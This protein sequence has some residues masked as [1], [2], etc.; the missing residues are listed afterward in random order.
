MDESANPSLRRMAARTKAGD[1]SRNT[2]YRRS[3]GRDCRD[4]RVERTVTC[5]H[6]CVRA[7][8]RVC[9]ISSGELIARAFIYL[10]PAN[11]RVLF[12][13]SVFLSVCEI[14]SIASTSVNNAGSRSD[15]YHL[16][17][18][19]SP[20]CISDECLCRTRMCV[21]ACMRVCACACACM[22][23]YA[24]LRDVHSDAMSVHVEVYRLI[25]VPYRKPIFVHDSDSY[26]LD[27]MRFHSAS[28]LV[29]ATSPRGSL[30]DKDF[31]AAITP[32]SFSFL[33]PAKLGW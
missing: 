2:R 3:R 15:R 31:V 12:H 28:D 23:H 26:P 11:L 18:S 16:S 29:R 19:V 20:T 5:V 13:L 30:S 6:V 22:C 24:R 33:V 10:M 7:R 25:G 9:L 32:F 17:I 14:S 8:V 4:R 1:L 27:S 21:Y